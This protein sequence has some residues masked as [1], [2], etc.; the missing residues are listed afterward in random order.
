[1]WVLAGND[2][3]RLRWIVVLIAMGVSVIPPVNRLLAFLLDKLRRPRPP[4]VRKLAAT[5]GALSSL[6][7]LATALVQGRDL[8]PKM[9]DECSYALGARMMA[10]GHLWLPAHPLADFF[11]SFFILVKPVYCSIYF[12]GT[13]LIFAPGA[14][15]GW[16]TWVLPIVLSGCIA[17]ILYLLITELIDGAAGLV[18]EVWIIS[19]GQFRT[20]STMT[21]SHL[22][23]LLMGLLMIW[24]WLRWR[25]NQRLGWAL[26]LG[27]CS[28]FAAIIRPADA[29]AYVLP[30]AIAMLA[31][32]RSRH[33]P[34]AVADGTRSVP[35][36]M[37]TGA[38]ILAGA[39]PF[40]V[41]QTIFNIGVT[42]HAFQTPY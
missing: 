29:V 14:K 41:L 4:T 36:T 30:I 34:R 19:L 38:W 39:A 12:P 24:V 27:I 7:L 13:A 6:Y 23:M 1:M 16:E 5:F 25:K 28:G 37:S 18:A 2:L 26:L 3:A 17:A 31:A 8:F 20:L 35:A 40:L 33:A 21:M 32:L 15:F 10:S 22:P 42:G 9:E 11:E